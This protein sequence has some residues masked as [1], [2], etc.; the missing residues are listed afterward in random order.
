MMRRSAEFNGALLPPFR[1][2]EAAR[3]GVKVADGSMRRL[4]EGHGL[5]VETRGDNA[6]PQTP[7]DSMR[8]FDAHGSEWPANYL[9]CWS[10][11]LR[12]VPDE[13]Y[14]PFEFAALL[15]LTVPLIIFFVG[16]TARFVAVP[17]VLTIV[18]VLYRSRPV[19]HEKL[20]GFREVALCALISALF[21]WACAYLPPFGRSWDWLKHFAV[22]NE[23]AR[24]PWPPVDEDTHTF[25][26]YALGYYLVPGLVV[27]VFGDRVVEPIVFL[28]TWAGLFVVLVLLLQKIRPSRPTPFLIIFLLFGGLDLVGWTL[29]GV[30]RSILATKEWWAGPLFAYEG[31]ATLFLWVPQHALPGMLGML[32]L[33][34]DQ[35][36][37][38]SPRTMG[39]LGAAVMFWSPFEALGLLPFALVTAAR[40]WREVFADPGNILCALILGIPLFSYLVAGSAGIPRGFTWNEDGFSFATYA[41]FIMLEAGL[42]IIAL[43]LCGWQH[44]RHPFLIVAILLILPLYRIGIY[45]DFTMR[46]CVP[47]LMLLAIAVATSVTEI[48]GYRWIPLAILITAGSAGSII[49]IIGRGNDGYVSAR[50]QSLRSGFLIQDPRFFL[51]YNAPLPSWVLR[52]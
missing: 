39:L 26:R 43:R 23:L 5:Q 25:L 44:L 28:E 41:I 51:Q 32:L 29:F 50:D 14:G 49:E 34:P 24:Y 9:R 21:L 8:A 6:A 42:Y 27:R 47:V 4:D 11:H 37:P 2:V 15:F 1:M 10:N 7:M 33:L 40:T 36:R 52:R 35:G 19:A 45:N 22:I 20:P 17:A 46:T 31:H 3:T 13:R 18:A 16:F 38:T 30:G 12:R 48:V